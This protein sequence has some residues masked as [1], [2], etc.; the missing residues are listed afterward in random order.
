MKTIFFIKLCLL[1]SISAFSQQFCDQELLDDW[2]LTLGP[3]VKF[4]KDFQ[5]YL[6]EVK[7]NEKPKIY[8][9]SF[10]LANNCTYQFNIFSSDKYAGKAAIELYSDTSALSKKLL[11]STYNAKNDRYFENFRFN[12]QKTGVYHLWISSPKGNETCA[13][14]VLSFVGK[15]E[16]EESKE[17]ND[18]AGFIKLSLDPSLTLLYNSQS[19]FK[20]GLKSPETKKE[21]TISMHK[22]SDYQINLFTPEN[23]QGIA[24]VKLYDD[25]MLL[26]T[27]YNPSNKKR[28]NDFVFK[29]RKSGTYTIVVE[30][31]D[32]K[33]TYALVAI[34]LI[35]KDTR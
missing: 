28:Y 21:F 33:E 15:F 13:V 3:N 18:L 35:K 8:K 31:T 6:P 16:D 11:G 22:G 4:L 23:P 14:G 29:C 12:C 19:Y 2:V 30:P 34:S 5:A 20:E 1:I 32:D 10:V 27:T 9:T 26:G 17:N 25:E 24:S 7:A